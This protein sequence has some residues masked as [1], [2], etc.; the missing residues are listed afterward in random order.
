MLLSDRS[1]LERYVAAKL[2]RLRTGRAN[3]HPSDCELPAALRPSTSERKVVL[4]GKEF[5]VAESR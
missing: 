2:E 5:S 4:Y 3:S 1:W